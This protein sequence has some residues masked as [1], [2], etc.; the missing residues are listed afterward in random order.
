[1]AKSEWVVTS[2]ILAVYFSWGGRLFI[3]A[4]ILSLKLNTARRVGFDPLYGA[5]MTCRTALSPCES[6]ESNLFATS[7]SSVRAVVVLATGTRFI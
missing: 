5:S 4:S 2:R 6:C 3:P 1:M 7:R